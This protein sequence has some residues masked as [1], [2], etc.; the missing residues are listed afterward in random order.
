MQGLSLGFLFLLPGVSWVY[1]FVL[2]ILC[3]LHG[4]LIVVFGI[5]RIEAEILVSETVDLILRVFCL[6]V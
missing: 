1:S 3:I 4:V 5:D 2:Q 6:S